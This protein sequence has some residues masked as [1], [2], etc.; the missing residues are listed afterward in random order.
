MGYFFQPIG[1]KVLGEPSARQSDPNV[2]E[3]Q[4]RVVSKQSAG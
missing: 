3:L 4:L 1:L 2:L